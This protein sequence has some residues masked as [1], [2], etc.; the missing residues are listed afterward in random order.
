MVFY[1]LIPKLTTR[2][3]KYKEDKITTKAFIIQKDSNKVKFFE[4][5]D[6]IFNQANNIVGED[7]NYT[8]FKRDINKGKD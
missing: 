2:I 4:Y 6:K 3:H 5:S 7:Q 1:G 8:S